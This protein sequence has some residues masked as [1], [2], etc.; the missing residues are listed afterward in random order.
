LAHY[1]WH[2]F[3]ERYIEWSGVTFT[4]LRPEI[5]MQNLLG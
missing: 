4:H 5:F 1:G 2:Q 3:I